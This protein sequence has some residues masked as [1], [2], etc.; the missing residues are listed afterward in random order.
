MKFPYDFPGAVRRVREA[1][2]D[3]FT[4]KLLVKTVA[5][6]RRDVLRLNIG[7]YHRRP[8]PAAFP[9]QA[10]EDVRIRL[11]EGRE[12]WHTQNEHHL[13]ALKTT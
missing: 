5:P 1:S 2:A 10:R 6:Q 13:R 9:E 3:I 7:Q 8:H 12:A 4:T 11:I